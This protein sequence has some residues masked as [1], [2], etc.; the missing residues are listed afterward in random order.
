MRKAGS[1]QN[2]ETHFFIPYFLLR[3][4]IADYQLEKVFLHN[5]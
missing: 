5:G 1:F 4:C 2:V 3:C